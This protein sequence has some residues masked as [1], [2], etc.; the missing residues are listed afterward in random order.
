LELVVKEIN[1]AI[2][3]RDATEMVWSCETNAG[4]TFT[5]QDASLATKQHKASWSTTQA[6][7][8]Q[9]PRGRAE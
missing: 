1:T 3:G 7:D 5:T 9:H 8:R 4:W 6:L 2:R